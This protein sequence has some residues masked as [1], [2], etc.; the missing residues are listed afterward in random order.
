MQN[1]I[2]VGNL[3]YTLDES[4]LRDTFSAYGE[5]DEVAFPKDRVTGRPR[6]FAFITFNKP[7]SAEQALVLDGQE[8]SGRKV[9]VKFALERK[10]TGT[11][12]GSGR[13]GDSRGDSRGW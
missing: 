5:I 6:G 11:G 1:K 3:S 4:S 7:E 13:R 12:G 8:L 10:A 2:Y 9:V